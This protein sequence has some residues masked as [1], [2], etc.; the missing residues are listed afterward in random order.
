MP[1]GVVACSE[2]GITCI[3]GSESAGAKSGEG[4]VTCSGGNG[5]RTAIHAIGNGNIACR[6]TASGCCDNNGEVDRDGF[7]VHRRV[8][9]IT[10]DGGGSGCLIDLMSF[11][12]VAGGE[13]GIASIRGSECASTKSGEGEVTSSSGDSGSTAIDTVGDSNIASG[14]AASGG[15]SSDCEVNCY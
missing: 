3:G 8:G 13:V 5:S 1:F 9:Q 15:I 6:C 14:C 4:N 7:P 11:G 10:G 12:V 2:V